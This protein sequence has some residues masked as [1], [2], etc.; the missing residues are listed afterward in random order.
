MSDIVHVSG[1]TQS[2]HGHAID[3]SAHDRSAPSSGSIGGPKT[4]HGK[5]N[6]EFRQKL[7]EAEKSADKPNDGYQ[8]RNREGTGALGRY[9][10]KNTALQDGGWK[11]AHGQWTDK[12][13]RHGVNSDQDFLDKPGAQE[14]AVGDG[15]RRAEEQ[16]R[17]NGSMNHV[18]KTYV[19]PD[20]T[21]VPVTAGG[22]AA[23][24]HRRGAGMTHQT[25]AKLE[26]KA[27][28]KPQKFSIGERQV[29]L[30]LRVFKDTPYTPGGW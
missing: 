6:S 2:R 7:A 23:A 19:G 15:L 30:R 25:L 13:R 11:D 8:E 9:Q 1:Y 28:G 5:S 10:L 3:V 26:R 21:P 4:W 27:K 12:A 18:G 29:I 17:K 14:V 20:G 24:A 22:V 16:A